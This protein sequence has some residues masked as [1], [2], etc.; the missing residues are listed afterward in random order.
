MNIKRQNNFRYFSMHNT[1]DIILFDNIEIYQS[2]GIIKIAL[3]QNYS[4]EDN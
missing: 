4:Q 3:N 2:L 1:V